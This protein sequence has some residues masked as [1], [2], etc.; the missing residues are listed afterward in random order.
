MFMNWN[1]PRAIWRYQA[2]TPVLASFLRG[3][4]YSSEVLVFHDERLTTC[5][6]SVWKNYIWIIDDFMFPKK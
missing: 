5:I 3:P 2:Q 6:M 1:F 4:S